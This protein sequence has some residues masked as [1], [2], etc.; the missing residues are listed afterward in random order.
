[1]ELAGAARVG[2][3]RGRRRATTGSGVMDLAFAESLAVACGCRLPSAS[4]PFSVASEAF[5]EACRRGPIAPR[6]L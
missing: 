2:R 4:G 1:M 6:R 5:S 3:M